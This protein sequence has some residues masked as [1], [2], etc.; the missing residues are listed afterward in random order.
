MSPLGPSAGTFGYSGPDH[1]ASPG[2]VATSF[3]AP[4]IRTPSPVCVCGLKLPA[5]KISVRGGAPP[6]PEIAGPVRT[7]IAGTL[8][9]M[10]PRCRL[11]CR[12]IGWLCLQARKQPRCTLTLV[13]G[14]DA[15]HA[16]VVVRR[17]DPSQLTKRRICHTQATH[18]SASFLFCKDEASNDRSM[19]RLTPVANVYRRGDVLPAHRSGQ[20]SARHER[21]DAHAPLKKRVL[22]LPAHEIEVTFIWI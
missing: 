16:V 10:Q 7:M 1:C 14:V 4:W 22:A 3:Q 21:V 8:G 12:V 9:R 17:R 5:M 6:A 20:Q 15:R 13:D 19:W 18:P 2:P 11:V